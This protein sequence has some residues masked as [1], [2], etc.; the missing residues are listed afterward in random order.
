MTRLRCWRASSFPGVTVTLGFML[1]TSIATADSSRVTP[2]ANRTTDAGTQRLTYILHCA[3]CHNVDG[4]GEPG[5]VPD[6]RGEISRFL[7]VDEGR[8]YL[9]QVPGTANSYL[10]D[11]GVA[12]LLN[13]IL[14]NFDPEH[15]PADFEPYTASEVAR[16]RG[17]AVSEARKARNDLIRQLESSGY[18]T[19]GPY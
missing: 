6:M 12:S 8:I 2:V 14:R 3:G 16:Y 18:A 19:P 10:D 13:W 7:S 9:I 17:T 1:C 4:S 5:I 11:S 15:I